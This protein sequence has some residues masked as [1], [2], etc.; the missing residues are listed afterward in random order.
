MLRER[1]DPRRVL[2]RFRV[3]GPDHRATG[4]AA[5]FP[6]FRPYVAGMLSS[7]VHFAF[8]RQDQSLFARSNRATTD[9]ANPLATIFPEQLADQPVERGRELPENGG[10]NGRAREERYEIVVTTR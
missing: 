4:S 7:L 6:R 5:W 3:P 9:V 2:S 10:L 1:T 8:L